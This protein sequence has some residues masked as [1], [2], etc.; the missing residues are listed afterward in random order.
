MTTP[1]EALSPHGKPATEDLEP[2]APPHMGQILV[3]FLP[4]DIPAPIRELFEA[5]D[6]VPMPFEEMTRGWQLAIEESQ[7][8]GTTYLVRLLRDTRAG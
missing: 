3:A 4:D 7:P 2:S 8:E 1:C 5:D 6:Y